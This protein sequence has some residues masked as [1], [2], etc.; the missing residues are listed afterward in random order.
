MLIH[1]NHTETTDAPAH[2]M[3]DV[4]TDYM[5]Y[6]QFNPAVT[7]VEVA[8]KNDDGAE[9]RAGRKT[10]V[11]KNACA[12]DRYLHDDGSYVIE[13]SYGNDTDAR[14][15]WTV[16]PIDETHCAFGIDAAMTLPFLKGV[17][18]KPLLRHLFYGINFTPFIAEA[19]RRTERDEPAPPSGTSQ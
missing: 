7:T 9:F 15:T 19:E 12:I 3:F 17:I 1:F 14:S 8:W 13:R 5:H 16:R 4:L 18:M 10:R 6:P 2:T 11:E